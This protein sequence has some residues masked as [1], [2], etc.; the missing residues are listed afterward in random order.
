MPRGGKKRG[1]GRKK[2]FNSCSKVSR[3]FS[4]CVPPGAC[5]AKA[6]LQSP[7]HPHLW[8]LTFSVLT[9]PG[10]PF[11]DPSL[12]RLERDHQ[13][14][15]KPQAS[16]LLEQEVSPHPPSCPQ[17]CLSC[18][19]SPK[20]RYFPTRNHTG[21]STHQFGSLVNGSAPNALT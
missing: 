19:T 9:C 15:L 8:A 6:G 5:V 3:S 12:W 7:P 11:S 18:P 16:G 4:G 1:G 17:L 21:A 2:G 10:F 20:A 13:R 14:P